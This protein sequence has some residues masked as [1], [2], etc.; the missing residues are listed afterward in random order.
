[1][2]K[3]IVD[4]I[5]WPFRLIE[6][7]PADSNQVSVRSLAATRCRFA[8]EHCAMVGTPSSVHAISRLRGDIGEY[9]PDSYNQSGLFAH[10]A[11]NAR[12]LILVLLAAAARKD[13]RGDATSKGTL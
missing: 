7:Q 1:M 3:I 13:P 4:N 11:C 6:R 12:E 5:I 9:A 8:T 10:F 2:Q